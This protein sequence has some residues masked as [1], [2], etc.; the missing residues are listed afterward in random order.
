M[1]KEYNT[2]F[3]R[4]KSKLLQQYVSWSKLKQYT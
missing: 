1:I 2:D 3:P 4:Q